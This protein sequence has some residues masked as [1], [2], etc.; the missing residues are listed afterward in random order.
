MNLTPCTR[1]LALDPTR[2]GFAYVLLESET[3]I[4]WGLVHA[5][6]SVEASIRRL[7]ELINRYTPELLVIEHSSEFG[8]RRGTRAREFLVSVDLLGLSGEITVERVSQEKVRQTF[9]EFK[10]KH[11]I[12]LS[13]L[14]RY[15]ELRPWRPRVRKAWMSEDERMNIFDALVLALT[16]RASSTDHYKPQSA[17]THENEN[18]ENILGGAPTHPS[19]PGSRTSR[20]TNREDPPAGQGTP[21]EGSPQTGG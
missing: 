21:G 19:I 6:R 14:D 15:P 20:A 4:D 5:G 12:A 18:P 3:L 13:L 1:L 8:R 7:D 9:A 2:D 16:Y 17:Y 10:G 11:A